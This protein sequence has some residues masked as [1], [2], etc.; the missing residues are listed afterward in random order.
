MCTLNATKVTD[1]IAR[2]LGVDLAALDALALAAAPG[3]DGTVLVP[4]FDGER[5]PDR[6]TRPAPSSA[7]DPTCLVSNSRA[8]PS[9]ASSAAC[10]TGWTRSTAAGVGT[11]GRLLLV[12]GG[13][14]SRAYRQI[15]ADLS[16]RPVVVPDAS[17][18]VA[19]GACVQAAAALHRRPP[20]EIAAAWG[21]GTGT[22][23]EPAPVDRD[24]VRARYSEAAHG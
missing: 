19:T 5:V 23:V 20:A 3:S 13:G 8:R 15:L 10:S 18:L 6:P 14:Q 21:L 4:Y 11:G 9:K 16:G 2:L 24:A 1:A 12:G 22:A 7:S 17:E